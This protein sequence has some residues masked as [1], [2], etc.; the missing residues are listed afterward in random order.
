M[1]K[2]PLSWW[3]SASELL[4]ENGVACQ[5]GPFTGYGSVTNRDYT[6]QGSNVDD[7]SPGESISGKP[8]GSIAPLDGKRSGPDRAGPGL[9]A[10]VLA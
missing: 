6:P 7:C 5:H 2:N 4:I 9:P 8:A 3:G 10:S 1:D